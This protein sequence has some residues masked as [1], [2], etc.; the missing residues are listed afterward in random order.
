VWQATLRD[1][2]GRALVQ[3][4]LPVVFDNMPPRGAR[5]VRPPASGVQGGKTSLVVSA[6]DDLSG[7]AD[8]QFFV[9]EPVD[10]KPPAGAKLIA[11][12]RVPTS[13][14]LW[15]ADLPLPSAAGTIT[16][17]AQFTNG[18]GLV[19]FASTSLQVTDKATSATGEI[20]GQVLE[21][22]RPQAALEVVLL[23]AGK[24]E[25][26]KAKSGADG[27]FQFVGVPPGDYTIRAVKP[28]SQRQGEKG[29]QVVAGETT[30]VNLALG[31]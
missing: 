21:G 10:N 14:E 24:A 18:A 30:I 31:L 9:G 11:A 29:V 20:R 6:W 22:Q 8:V 13:P 28:A 26:G 4:S 5:F 15:S 1:A 17:T 7:V 23:N 27:A 19:S 16:V 2:A 25:V 12:Q 3:T